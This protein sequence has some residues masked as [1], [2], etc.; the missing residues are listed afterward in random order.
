MPQV[1]LQ[2][3]TPVL[4]HLVIWGLAAPARDNIQEV[5]QLQHRLAVLHGAA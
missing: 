1:C 4:E 3:G 2:L 5:L